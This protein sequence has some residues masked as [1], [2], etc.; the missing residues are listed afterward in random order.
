MLKNITST[1]HIFDLTQ[2][3]AKE[4]QTILNNCGYNLAVDGIVGH[5][6]ATAF[7][8]FKESNHLEYPFLIGS[9]TI[10]KLLRFKPIHRQ[11]NQRGIDLIKKWEGFRSK[12]YLCPAKVPTIGYGNTFY[13]DGRKVK[14]GEV[15]SQNE[16]ERLLKITVNNFAKEVDKLVKVRVTDNQ[17]SALV[18]LAYNIGIGAFSGSTLL[19]LL[20]QGNYDGA[21]AQFDRW[22]RAGGVVSQGLINRRNEERKLF[23]S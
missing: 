1:K 11:V 8:H 19:R 20:N 5:N 7:R 22:N 9:S 6:T 16:A 21:S 13:P 3:E 14:L 18:S 23:R 17:F 10:D 4:L 15:I 12:A 2:E